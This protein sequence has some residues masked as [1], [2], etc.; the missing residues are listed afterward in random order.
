M[1]QFDKKK[2]I[3]RNFFVVNSVQQTKGDVIAK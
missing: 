2:R 3:K 1:I